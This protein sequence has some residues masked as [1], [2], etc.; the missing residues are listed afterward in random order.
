[1]AGNKQN[2]ETWLSSR[3]KT[4][5]GKAS[6][7]GAGPIQSLQQYESTV[8]RLVEKFDLSDPMV[9]NEFE[10]NGD[11][12]PVLQFQVKSATITVRYQPGRWPAAF[13]VTVEAQ[14][15]VGSVFGL[16]DPTLDLSRDK[17]DGMEG[18]IKGA[19][20]SNQNQFSCELEDEWDLAMLVRIVRSGGLLD[21]A[22]IPKS[23]SSKED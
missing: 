11:H 21:W 19:Y 12:W 3:P 23:E 15:A 8:Q 1:M 2:F 16:F 22:A 17:I 14:S 20:R 5:S 7:S 18:Y 4:G 13:T 9:I 10:H 6:V